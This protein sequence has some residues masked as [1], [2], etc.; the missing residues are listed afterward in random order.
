MMSNYRCVCIYETYKSP[1]R[2]ELRIEVCQSGNTKSLSPFVRKVDVEDLL[3]TCVPESRCLIPLLN[4]MGMVKQPFRI[5]EV[6][7]ANEMVQ[8]LLRKNPWNGVQ[9]NGKGSVKKAVSVLP[10]PSLQRLSRG[11][12]LNG[13]LYIT[14]IANWNKNIKVRL[15]YQDALTSFF[16]TYNECPYLTSAVT[17]LLRDPEAEKKLLLDLGANVNLELGDVTFGEY[18]IDK[19][20]LLAKHGWKILVAKTK[21]PATQVYL[22]QHPSG[23]NWFTSDFNSSADDALIEQMLNNYLQGR[24]YIDSKGK[25]SLFRAKDITQ[26]EAEQLSESLP[27]FNIKKLYGVQH[28]LSEAEK[29]DILSSVSSGVKAQL[30]SYQQAGVLWLAEM[31]KNHHGCL[32]ADEMGLGKTLQVLSHL[33]SL[34]CQAGKPHLVIAPT[35]LVYNWQSEIAKFIPSWQNDVAIQLHQPDV[36]KRLLIVSYDILRL[37]TEAYQQL[38]Y[39]TIIIDEA[40]I[41]KNR[42]TKKYKAIKTLKAQ[43]H[44]ILTG[45]PIEN[46]IDDIWSHFMLLMPEMKTLY[47]MLSKQCQSKSDEA[48]LEMSRKFLKPFILRRTKQDVLKD[49]PE[50]IEKT[51]YIEMAS[52]E[53]HLYD[54]VHKMVVQAL[55]N[56][57]SGRIESIALEGLLRLRQVCVS[58][59]LIPNAIFKGVSSLISSKLQT[60]LDYIEMFRSKQEKVLVFSQFVGALEEMERILDERKIRYEKI[61][62]ETRD[63]VTPIERFQKDKDTTVFLISLKAGGVGLNLTA[64]NNVILLDD[65]WNPAVEDQAFARAHRIG[66]KQNV[67]VFR[68]IC[69]DTV[70]EKVLQL[71]EK[72]RQ[73]I[74][75]FNSASGKLSM[76]ELQNLLI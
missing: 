30:R 54:N 43:H 38:E 70:E 67:M 1:V 4:Q 51:I 75:M 29:T 8:T 63:R 57:V 64:A 66:Q 17:L 61:Y 46:S 47:A 10:A 20:A 76:S 59:K 28:S 42:D 74:D 37:N 22:K 11:Q 5:P 14:N 13:E 60:A 3:Y 6:A 49:L 2:I 53:R 68:L 50:L 21:G 9:V 71:Q 25:L 69:K 7:L 72:K 27:S 16:P 18:D 35:S 58:P 32:L 44:I 40:Q 19:L 12:L 33:Y 39:D 23:I 34:R 15:A 65:W 45:T 48:F 62:G 24:N 36:S 73:T 55:T 41:I 26:V 56:G 31:R 52:A